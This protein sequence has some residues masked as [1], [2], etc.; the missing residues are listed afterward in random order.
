MTFLNYSQI[1]DDLVTLI[2]DSDIEFDYVAAH[3]DDYER[4]LGNTNYCNITLTRAVNEVTAGNNYTNRVQ[5]ELEIGALDLS[6]KREAVTIR[7]GLVNSVQDLVRTNQNFSSFLES[8]VLTEVD[9]EV[10]GRFAQDEDQ[11]FT[12]TALITLEAIIYSQ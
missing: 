4:T 10:F 12:A 5:F 2:A 8:V 6:S 11:S 1:V 3:M 9:F 7:D